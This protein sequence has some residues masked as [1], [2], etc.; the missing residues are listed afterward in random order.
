MHSRSPP[1]YSKH[2]MNPLFSLLKSDKPEKPE[3]NGHDKNGNADKPPAPSTKPHIESV[4]PNAAMPGGE[5]AVH[6][7]N[8]GPGSMQPHATIGDIPAAILLSRPTQTSLRIP[9]GSISGEILIHN[10]TTGR[11]TEPSN[12]LYLRVAVP[13]AEN[14]H[15]VSNPRRGRRRKRLRHRVRAARPTGSG[16][17]LLH[18]A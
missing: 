14:L 6:G 11:I 10:T 7:T 2:T 12:P 3:K 8:L 16:L 4:T 18:P 17:H 9:E 15:P 13:M 1:L 5:V